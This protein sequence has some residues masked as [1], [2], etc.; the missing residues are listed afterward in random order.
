[1]TD[2]PPH[3]LE[4][5][6]K[7]VKESIRAEQPQHP[8]PPQPQ[9]QLLAPWRLEEFG[10][11]EPDLP[12]DDRHPPGDVITV[13]RDTIYRNVDAF[14]ER[15]KD[16]IASKTPEVVRDNLHLCLRGSASRWYTFEI[17]PV[18][19]RSIRAD[20]T[21]DLDQW[22]DRLQERFRPRMAQAA[23]ENSLLTFTR[24]DVRNGK[25]VATYFQSKILRARVAGFS[26]VHAQLTQVYAGI[27]VY[28]RRDLTEPKANT[29]FSDYRT[30][31]EEKESLWIETY[32]RPSIP[33]SIS[34]PQTTATVN[35]LYQQPR[36]TGFPPQQP[37]QTN[38]Q[39]QQR[40]Q[41]PAQQQMNP[42]PYH[43]QR[44]QIF[45]HP[46]QQCVLRNQNVSPTQDTAPNRRQ[47][48]A[49]NSQATSQQQQ[50]IDYSS[51]P[52]VELVNF[53]GI[54]PQPLSYQDDVASLAG[55]DPPPDDDFNAW[56][57]DNY[58]QEFDDR[59][60]AYD[61]PEAY[62]GSA[63]PVA[64]DKF[65]CNVC[66]TPFPS[67]NKLFLHLRDT[68]HQMSLRTVSPTTLFAAHKDLSANVVYSCAPP[69][70]GSGMA[71]RSYN[72]LEIAMRPKPDAAD[73]AVCVDTGCG[74]TC[75]D[76]IFFREHYPNA[77]AC[78]IPP[79]D[80]VGMG[81]KTH[82][83]S[84][85]SIIT[86]FLPGYKRENTNP[87]VAAIQREVHIVN[88]LPCKLLIGT[89]V[90]EPE[91][92]V[93]DLPNRKMTI[94]SCGDIQC[95]LKITPRG[96]PVEH[97]MVRTAKAITV[98]PRTRRLIPVRA[99][100]LPVDRDFQFS[101][102]YDTSTAF[103]A[104]SGIFPEAIVNSQ[105]Q[106]VAYHNTSDSP[107]KIPAHLRIGE[108]SDWEI[109]DQ[110]TPEDP[111]I[112][113]CHFNF[114]RLLPSVAL[115]ATYGISAY[116]YARSTAKPGEVY[117]PD[118]ESFIKESPPT[119]DI[120]S[121]LPPLDEQGED[122][123]KFGAEAIE[124]NTTDDITPEQI[125][126]VRAVLAEFPT[127]WEDRVGRV[128]EPEDDWLE[129][130]LKPGEVI[131]SKGRYRVSTRDEA[132]IDEV[133]DQARAD[134]RMSA[135]EG[136]ISAGWPVFVV[137]H[138]GKGR[139]VVDLRGL[140]AKVVPDAYPLP[141]QDE[142]V[143][144]V[145]GKPW[146]SDFDLI[147]AFYQRYVKKKDR[148]KLA[149]IT[150]RGQEI[151][152]V[153]PMGYCGS[154]SHMQKFMDKV[155]EP[156]KAYAKCYVDNVIIFSDTFKEHVKHV[157][158]VL[159]IF[160]SLGMTLSPDKCHVAYH[161]IE[162][163]GHKVDRFGL[164]TL[165]E[166]IDAIAS[167]QYPK[168]LDELEYFLGLTGYYRH[169]V[170][171][172]AGI[173]DPLQQLK[174]RL[175]KGSARL[176]RRQRQALTKNS[177]VPEPTE[178]DLASFKLLKDALCSDL[179]LIHHDPTLPLLYY[180]D[181]S[182]VGGLALAIHQVPQDAMDKHS[183]TTEDIMNGKYDR[184]LEK[185]VMYLSRMLNKHEVHYWPTELEIAGII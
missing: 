109:A 58:H 59:S 98:P 22:T 115:A 21:P 162:L 105:S 136:V 163:L 131:E 91:R 13:G 55:H 60:S 102:H 77:I 12:V 50:L 161:S 24:D 149:V 121:L 172:Y 42:C 31:L 165:K 137:W 127:L 106:C 146:Q 63:P 93:I 40:R 113:D 164:S 158:A 185:P 94:R 154:P 61:S 51:T 120:Y 116:Q 108:L 39:A 119:T 101:P 7:A 150:H 23:Q 88:D 81:G 184:K 89:D 142:V 65:S 124:V 132:K 111:D 173:A 29:D 156:H 159:S 133:F 175:L 168:T 169:F 97:R 117:R 126:Q 4:A 73:Q 125:Q 36:Q 28:L 141:R 114:A 79:I 107:V 110:V 148:W 96:K 19:K 25:K 118:V 83:S 157:H 17:K 182:V 57:S 68:K 27:E 82:S 143:H 104:I 144:K 129:I 181:S 18:D 135:A 10:L 147:K 6:I 69:V 2:V 76:R 48:S 152:N 84:E 151:F 44:G 99:K 92:V 72:Y 64:T 74:M 128:I 41:A 30:L 46:G 33:S 3:Q 176:K 174:T 112:V 75:I 160:A 90:L 45:Y 155:L 177:T 20:L 103:L 8:P 34:R 71:F 183:L 170:A 86:I 138:K 153:T 49:A 53:H 16:A 87:V 139:P 38:F 37:R 14:L 171:R 11:F 134:G 43:F 47:L 179:L 78:T 35:R 54:H 66:K 70:V 95:P 26:S 56:A 122:P 130:P 9:Q 123:K 52:I 100:R 140:N 32:V 62:F 145:R 85:Y 1:M 180:F 166:K 178:V 80:I 5:I 15:M 167:L 67:R